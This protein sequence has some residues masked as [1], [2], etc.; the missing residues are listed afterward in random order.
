MKKL[1][2]FAD[3]D[4][5]LPALLASVSPENGVSFLFVEDRGETS[6]AAAL[7]TRC[8]AFA[9]SQEPRV[10]GKA[11]ELQRHAAR[12]TLQ[13]PPEPGSLTPLMP[14]QQQENRRLLL[15]F[16]CCCCKN[17]RRRLQMCS[18][19]LELI[20]SHLNVSTEGR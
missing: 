6:C 18:L 1:K 9:Q 11:A 5:V 16:L 15:H 20:L 17:K 8:S 14:T 7:W 4:H 12:R 13:T 3:L 2:M 19:V 10:A